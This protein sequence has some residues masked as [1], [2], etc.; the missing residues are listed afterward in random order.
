[1][2]SDF[3]S[4]LSKKC[5]QLTWKGNI[6]LLSPCPHVQGC[7][8]E[9]AAVCCCC[10][11]PQPHSEQNLQLLELPQ[12]KPANNPSTWAGSW[13]GTREDEE[14]TR[15]FPSLRSSASPSLNY[16]PLY[17]WTSAF[18]SPWNLDPFIYNKIGPKFILYNS[19]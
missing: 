5:W 14:I 6:L 17:Y 9:A 16:S 18:P 15:F 1:M 3:S 2:N 12:P 10:L 4:G 19:I 7:L 13:W 11:H 8:P